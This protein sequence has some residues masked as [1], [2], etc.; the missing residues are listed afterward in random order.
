MQ[1]E[2]SDF[3]TQT[4]ELIRWAGG[5]MWP[6]DNLKSYFWR[7]HKRTGGHLSVRVIR[8]AWQGQQISRR[9]VD[10]LREAQVINETAQLADELEA[11]ANTMRK[12]DQISYG[13]EIGSISD[14]VRA[15]RHIG[16]DRNQ[17]TRRSD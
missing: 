3:A 14:A 5:P 12:T 2:M 7:L 1:H 13:A 8:A 15:L 16:A 17:R 11:L 4:R 6:G 9:T 10:A